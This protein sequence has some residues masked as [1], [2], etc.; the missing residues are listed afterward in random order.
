V[1]GARSLPQLERPPAGVEIREVRDELDPTGMLELAAWRWHVPPE[2]MPR[3]R[4]VARALELGNP[5]AAVR[6]WIARRDGVPVAKAFLNLA[7][8]AA[9]LYGVATKPEARG[10]GLA[11]TLTLEALDAARQAG[12]QLGVLHSTPMA[13]SLYE[14]IGFRTIEP[15]RVFAPPQTLHI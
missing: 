9:G 3:L 4:G 5:G 11:R 1:P 6:C 14:K 10:P 15:F 12:Y 2:V 8:G 13:R 7:A